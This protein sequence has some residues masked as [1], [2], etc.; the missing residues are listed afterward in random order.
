MMKEIELHPDPDEPLNALVFKI[1][2][3]P[4]MGRL[5]YF[6]VY[7]GKVVSGVTAY[8]S[9]SRRRER[10]WSPAADVC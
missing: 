5:A 1:V 9:R 4:Y 8:N 10:N 7:S 2:S 3:D 6:R